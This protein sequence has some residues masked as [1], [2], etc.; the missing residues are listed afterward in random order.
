M[1]IVKNSSLLSLLL[2]LLTYMVTGWRLASVVTNWYVWISVA[3]LSLIIAVILTTPLKF[4]SPPFHKWQHS[5]ARTFLSF[6]G[7]V[8]VCIGL[9]LI[10]WIFL[11]IQALL[12]VSAAILASLDLRKAGYNPLKS[13]LILSAVCLTGY[14]I[15]IWS[16]QILMVAHELPIPK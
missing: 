9:I 14:S 4:L 12:M 3:I 6:V 1:Y 2:L 15:G 5:D 8:L 11:F 10:T 7:L 16:Y 13:C